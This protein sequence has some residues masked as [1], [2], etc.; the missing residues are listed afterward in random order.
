LP[1]VLF[2]VDVGHEKIAVAEATKLGIPI[3]AV[4]DTNNSPDNIDYV[5]PGNDDAIRSIALYAKVAADTIIESRQSI[6]QRFEDIGDEF[7]EL[8][9]AGRVVTGE[10]EA[11][12]DEALRKVMR[13]KALAKKSPRKASQGPAE[14]SGRTLPDPEEVPVATET[15]SGE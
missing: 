5:I 11:A 9:D 14:E 8:D 3:V 10:N 2:V 1:D 13:K 7:V 15:A 6:P 4:V 12:S